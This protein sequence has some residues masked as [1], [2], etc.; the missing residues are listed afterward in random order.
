[1]P[2]QDIPLLDETITQLPEDIR[3]DLAERGR[4]DLFFFNSGI[5]GMRDM[6]VSCHGPLCAWSQLNPKQFKMMLMP[7]DHLKTSVITIGGSMQKVVQNPENRIL[8]GNES[9][10]NAGR[11]LRSIRQHAEGNRV[12]RALYSDSV[13]RD[14]RKVRWN[15]S[16]LDF[17][18][19]GHYPE[20]TIDSI[21][22]TGAF[23]SRHYTHITWDDP[24]SEEAVKSEKVMED[25]IGRMSKS[26]SL[27]VDPGVDTIWLVGTRWAMYDVYSNWA[28]VFGDKLG[29]FIRAALEFNPLTGQV[30]PIWPERFTPDVLALKRATYDSEYMWSC[31]MMNNPRNSEFQ[32]LNVDDL[33]FWEWN[34]DE[35]VCVLRNVDGSVKR[36]VPL[37]MLDVTVTVDLAAA[38]KI[39]DDRNAVTTVGVTPWN[40][41]IVLDSWAKRCTSIE[42][43]DKLFRL[44]DRFSPR[45]YGIE[46]V[47]YQKTLKT[48]VR[49][50][51]NDRHTYLN[52]QPLPA[53]GKKEQRI[54]SLQPYMA[55][56]RIFVRAN[57]HI[58]RNEMAE[59][60]LGEHDDA[61]E[62]LSMHTMLFRGQ[63]SPMARSRYKESEEKLIRKIRQNQLEAGVVG[64]DPSKWKMQ[65]DF[66]DL[67][68]FDR[69]PMQVASMIIT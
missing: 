24:I 11:M 13:Y 67:D 56:G 8:I 43:I 69:P 21:G 49:Q 9:G 55:T 44:K 22:M 39:Q 7:R 52:I 65:D 15:D 10:T 25:T 16:E 58:L 47:G 42:V 18:R 59:F 48:F 27:L 38:E 5:L 31:L 23:T 41:A 30:E 6:T 28:K 68:E 14:T 63:M 19:K 2:E 40:E 57:Q 62:G 45:V 46:D 12:F 32:D 34:S 35:T 26:M 3:S 66:L 37:S 53:R 51:M 4:R 1:M 33:M 29:K 36:E 20:P 64:T 61:V 54:R 60:P 17:V 50:E